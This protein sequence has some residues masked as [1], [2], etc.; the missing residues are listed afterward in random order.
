MDFDSGFLRVWLAI[1]AIWPGEHTSLDLATDLLWFKFLSFFLPDCSMEMPAQ[2]NLA[3]LSG[4]VKLWGTICISN[5][6][7]GIDAFIMRR[8]WKLQRIYSRQKSRSWQGNYLALC[9]FLTFIGGR[10]ASWRDFNV[11][12]ILFLWELLTSDVSLFKKS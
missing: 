8:C 10:M 9:W 3:W 6:S 11:L 7:P 2:H 12:F 4:K 1:G 5:D